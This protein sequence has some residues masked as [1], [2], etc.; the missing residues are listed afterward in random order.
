MINWIERK[1]RKVVN[2][3]KRKIG[4]KEKETDEVS[5]RANT[6]VLYKNEFDA[7]FHN[8]FTA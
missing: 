1:N 3:R 4:L 2:S 5:G 6:K 8:K 7:F